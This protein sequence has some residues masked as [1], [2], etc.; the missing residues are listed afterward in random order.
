MVVVPQMYALTDTA[1]DNLLA[2]VRGGGTLVCGFLTG[3][4]DRDDRIR[5]GGMDPR[6][7][8]LFGIRVLHEWWPLEP[9]ETAPCDGFDGTLWS[10]EIEP[11]GTAQETVAYRGGELDGLPALL[12]KGRAWY[13]S[14]LPTPGALRGLLTRIAAGAGVRPV[15]AGLP[16][17]VEAVRRGDLLFLLHHGRD[18][19]TVEVPGT[20]RDLLTGSPVTDRVTLGRYAAAVLKPAGRVA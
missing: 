19:V 18:P 1:V 7:R 4:A 16:A 8:E 9:G 10:E 2:Y 17:G 20:H 15:L 12:R 14:T 11:D 13:L 3:V 6:L 5:P